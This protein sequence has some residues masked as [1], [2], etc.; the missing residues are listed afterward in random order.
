[1]ASGCLAERA[2]QEGA[3]SRNAKVRKI[4]FTQSLFSFFFS[5]FR[6]LRNRTGSPTIIYQLG[7]T[8]HSN[9]LLRFIHLINF[10]LRFVPLPQTVCVHNIVFSNLAMAH[11]LHQHNPSLSSSSVQPP[12]IILCCYYLPEPGLTMNLPPRFL[13][14]HNLVTDAPPK[15]KTIPYH[16][17]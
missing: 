11:P 8:N 15:A 12:T 7:N 16:A 6:H 10:F 14:P 17:Y 4:L 13:S 1:M 2:P 3:L 5:I 9:N